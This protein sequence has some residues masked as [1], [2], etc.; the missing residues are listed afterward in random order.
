MQD[1][2]LIRAVI[3]RGF[4]LQLF[5]ADIRPSSMDW[6]QGQPS[7]TLGMDCRGDH[8]PGNVRRGVLPCLLCRLSNSLLSSRTLAWL[9]QN[10]CQ[11]CAIWTGRAS[12]ARPML[13]LSSR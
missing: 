6:L 12:L 9:R 7:F 2:E 13:C 1:C 8:Y 3:H 5:R 11:N 4:A 10:N